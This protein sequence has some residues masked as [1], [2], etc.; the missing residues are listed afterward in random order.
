MREYRICM[1]VGNFQSEQTSSTSK[2]TTRY[3][4]FKYIPKGSMMG[5]R[6]MYNRQE[7]EIC[8]KSHFPRILHTTSRST[9]QVERRRQYL[10][11]KSFA[12]CISRSILWEVFRISPNFDNPAYTRLARVVTE[13]ESYHKHQEL[14][15]LRSVFLEH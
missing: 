15:G 1:H 10:V 4:Q 5:V 8:L 2:Y 9:Q 14:L 7:G 6:Y 13:K 3:I 12:F 11:A